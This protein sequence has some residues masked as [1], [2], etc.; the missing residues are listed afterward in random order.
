MA[1][2]LD[3]FLDWHLHSGLTGHPGWGNL[4][5]NWLSEARVDDNPSG[6]ASPDCIFSPILVP[7]CLFLFDKAACGS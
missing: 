7:F 1:G 2:V 5:V 4:S 6:T 3:L